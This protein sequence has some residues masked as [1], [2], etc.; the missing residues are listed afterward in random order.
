VLGQVRKESNDIEQLRFPM[1]GADL[2]LT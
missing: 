1:H 2:Y